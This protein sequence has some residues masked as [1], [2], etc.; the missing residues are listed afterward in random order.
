MTP[1]SVVAAILLLLFGIRLRVEQTAPRRT[2]DLKS[3]LV[4]YHHH[5][6]S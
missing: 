6:V 1:H 4:H 3:T 2:A 5:L